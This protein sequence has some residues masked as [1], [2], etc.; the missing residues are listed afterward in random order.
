M[1][2]GR[3]RQRDFWVVDKFIGGALLFGTRRCAQVHWRAQDRRNFD[4]QAQH[5]RQENRHFASEE[6]GR[7]VQPRINRAQAGGKECY[8]GCENTSRHQASPDRQQGRQP[9]TPRLAFERRPGR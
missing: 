7:W 8:R 9:W 2:D 4:D 1:D 5:G 6:R 3:K